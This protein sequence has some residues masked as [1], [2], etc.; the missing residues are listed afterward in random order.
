MEELK[1]ALGFCSPGLNNVRFAHI[2]CF[3]ESGLEF[4][5]GLFNEFE[6][7]ADSGELEAY[8]NFYDPKTGQGPSFSGF[9]SAT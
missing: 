9:L 5:L 6:L 1:S 4:L 2:R 7:G 8:A 3:P